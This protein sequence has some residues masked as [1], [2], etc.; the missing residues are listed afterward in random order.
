VNEF[1][2]QCTTYLMFFAQEFNRFVL[3]I[4]FADNLVLVDF[5]FFLNKE[6]VLGCFKGSK[7]ISP[8]CPSRRIDAMFSQYANF[9]RGG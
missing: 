9:L 5:G 4:I 6:L 3:S 8:F 2:D 1:I 7:G